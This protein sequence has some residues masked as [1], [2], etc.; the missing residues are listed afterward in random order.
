MDA[1]GVFVDM[2]KADGTSYK[3]PASPIRFGDENTDPKG[4]SPEIGEHTL[5]VLSD[6][7][8]DAATRTAL[9]DNKIIGQHQG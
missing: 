2:P 6:L 8:V 1:A 7:G 5:Q 9:L 3:A 4:P